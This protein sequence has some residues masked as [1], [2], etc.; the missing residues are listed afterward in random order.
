MRIAT[1][2]LV[3]FFFHMYNEEF[4][5]KRLI[6]TFQYPRML[7]CLFNSEPLIEIGCPQI[8]E[9]IFEVFIEKVI[10]EVK[11]LAAPKQVRPSFSYQGVCL[12]AFH[13]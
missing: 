6:L 7:Q 9:Q 3:K 12:T 4:M 2:D 10:F 5:V 11:R 13:C 1:L 8:G